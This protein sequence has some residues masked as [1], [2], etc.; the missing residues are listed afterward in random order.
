MGPLDGITLRSRYL[1]SPMT[2]ENAYVRGHGRTNNLHD[3]VLVNSL[4]K[5]NEPLL[6]VKSIYGSRSPPCDALL[7]SKHQP[8]PLLI[9]EVCVPSTPPLA[10]SLFLY[11]EP[12]D[13]RS[14]T[15]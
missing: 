3:R 1:A 7:D 15:L 8:G 10:S 6:G 5:K 14:R 12:L 4:T 9:P 13:P 11:S 2:F